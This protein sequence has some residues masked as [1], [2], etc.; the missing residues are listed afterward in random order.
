MSIFDMIEGAAGS[1]AM[2]QIG[3]R[4]GLA[5]DQLQSVIASLAPSILPKLHAQAQHGGLDATAGGDA[6]PPGTQEAEEHGNSVLASIF[7]SKQTSRQVA[8]QA[9]DQTGVSVD[10]IKQVLPQIA[11]VAAGGMQ[12]GQLGGGLGGLLSGIGV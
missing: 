8:Q 3:Q 1:A 4:V 2:G 5:P 12:R 9:S 11:S 10:K 7:G 6:P